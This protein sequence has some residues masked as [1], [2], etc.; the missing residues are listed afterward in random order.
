MKNIVLFM[1]I[2][3][4]GCK[5][6]PAVID[7]PIFAKEKQR[8]LKRAA[9]YANLKPITV[10]ASFCERSTGDKHD[11]YS[12][13]DYWWPDPENPDGPYIRK[14]GMT[15]PDNFIAHRKAMIR[16][17]QIAGALASAYLV[18][19][20]KSYV[21]KLAPHL[22]AWFL[23]NK[24]LMNPNL[25]YGQAIMGR[26]TGR[27]IG[28]IDTIHL[29][30]VA[31]A[32]KVVET[33][34][35]LSKVEIQGIKDWFATYLEWMTTHEYGIKE[36]DN[37]NNHS[38]CWAIQV[39][40]FAELTENETELQYVRDFYK[41]TLL[42]N[43]MAENGSFPLELKRTKPYGYS[44][45]N[46]D[47][48]TALCQVASV[49]TN[50]LFNYITDDGKHI[51]KGIEFLYPFTKDKSK[52]PNDKDVM[53]WEEWPVRHPFLLFGGLAL[54]NQ[55]YTQ[56]WNELDPDFDNPEVIRNMPIR[57]PLLWLN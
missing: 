16:F 28:I 27:G 49:P 39:A 25:M 18:T 14:D 51:G 45:F 23:N 36:R 57:Y 53:Y 11:F 30:E 20:D 17:S 56:L 38:V 33:A 50:N 9:D 41:H 35:V 13:G 4:C 3:L 55:T 37:G 43:Q 52:W 5:E 1:A 42:P 34:G 6:T 54:K 15:N 12:E 2:L 48:M 44:L 7:K 40:V 46:L 19:S 22:K 31:K 32:V 21:E 26:V 8:V 24:T 47:A 29:M 10:T